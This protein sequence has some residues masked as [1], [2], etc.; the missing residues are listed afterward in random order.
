MEMEW[1]SRSF[2]Q[3]SRSDGTGISTLPAAARCVVSFDDFKADIEMTMTKV[4]RECGLGV[5]KDTISNG[6]GDLVLPSHVLREHTARRRTG[7][8]VDKSS[9][10]LGIDE[11]ELKVELGDYIV[12]CKSVSHLQETD[13]KEGTKSCVDET[14]QEDNHCLSRSSHPDERGRDV[15]I[16]LQRSTISL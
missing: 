11:D 7:Y 14:N 5:L 3:C 10:E 2:R 8:V 16:Q 12:W 1:Y 13:Q 6:K 4:Y 9:K 15:C